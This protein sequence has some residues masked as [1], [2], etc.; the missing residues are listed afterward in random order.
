MYSYI[1]Y[2]W[3]Y[4]YLEYWNYLQTMWRFHSFRA[5]GIIFMLGGGVLSKNVGDHGWPPTKNFK[6]K[7][8]KIPLNSC[9]K[10]DLDLKINNQNLI[11]S[12]KNPHS[13]YETQVT[14]K[15][16]L[17]IKYILPQHSQ[18]TFLVGGRKK[19]LH[20]TISTRPRTAFLEDLDSKCLY[21]PVNLRS[22]ILFPKT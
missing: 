18:N 8:T 15:T 14:I 4:M 17:I 2:N 19:H 7:L 3:V 21:I 12:L 1:K 16:Y 20:C 11:F 10:E 9:K 13:F 22:K 5:V 6:Y